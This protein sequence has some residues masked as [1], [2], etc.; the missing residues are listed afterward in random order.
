VLDAVLIWRF[1]ETPYKY[2]A[3]KVAA[4][5]IACAPGDLKDNLRKVREFSTLAKQ[6]G[7]E[8]IVFPE[9]VDT[10]YSMP[11]IQTH[12][13]SW[14][15]GA[16]PELQKIARELS[17]VIVCGVS[18]RDGEDIYNAQVVVDVNGEI[19]SKYRKIWSQPLHLTSAS[20]F[21]RATGL[22]VARSTSSMWA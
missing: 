5:Q 9:M 15:K 6:S 3:M 8:L 14:N 22:S 16:V 21:L 11:A 20:V 10:G 4:A 13:T 19:I 12:A 17:L 18:E 2:K 7:V 1:T